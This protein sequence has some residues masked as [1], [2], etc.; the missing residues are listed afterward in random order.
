MIVEK[1]IV[2]NRPIEEVFAFVSDSRNQ[3]EWDTDVLEIRLT[4]DNLIAVGTEIH[5]VRR[6][7][8]RKVESVSQVVEYEPPTK[9]T[10]SG[11]SPF[12]LTGYITLEPASEGTRVNWKWEGKPGGFFALAEKMITTSFAKAAESDLTNIKNILENQIA[13]NS[14]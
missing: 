5:E 11:T 8:G 7:L 9:Y 1:S 3:T 13:P 10:R 2:I 4:P 12:P 14:A 6:F